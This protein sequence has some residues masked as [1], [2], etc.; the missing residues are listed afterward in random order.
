MAAPH[1]P[2]GRVGCGPALDGSLGRGALLCLQRPRRHL[3]LIGGPPFLVYKWASVGPLEAP[4]GG[5]WG[6][7][8]GVRLRKVWPGVGWAEA[9]VHLQCT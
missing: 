2:R 1:W 8:V 3:P 7:H 9:E 6:W 5:A 4:F